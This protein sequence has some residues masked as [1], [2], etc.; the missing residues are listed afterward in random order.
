MIPSIITKQEII[1][2][3]EA[4]GRQAA[5]YRK[6]RGVSQQALAVKLGFTN[7]Y[8]SLLE[9]GH[10]P[11]WTSDLLERYINGIS[12]IKSHEKTV[13]SVS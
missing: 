2:D 5:E 9:S 4:T 6:A 10:R 7:A 1:T 12:D 13:Q 8:L 11:N 3:H